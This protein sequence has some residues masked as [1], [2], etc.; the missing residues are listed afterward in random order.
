LDRTR[1]YA[2]LASD[3]ERFRRKPYDELARLVGGPP[4]E[5]SV[6]TRD[7][8]LSVEV[9]FRWEGDHRRGVRV[10]ATAYGPSWWRLERLEES[11][12]V[13]RPDGDA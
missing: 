3:L 2:E 11:V 10:T 5:R 1:A 8:P 6:E 4:V 13:P 9:F 7:G 12:T